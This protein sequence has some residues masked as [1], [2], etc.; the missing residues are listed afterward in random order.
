MPSSS[1]STSATGLLD[2]NETVDDRE[3]ARRFQIALDL[4]ETGVEI[5]R[6]NLRRR[7]P[8]ESDE[9]IQRRLAAWLADRPGAKYGDAPGRV[10]FLSPPHGG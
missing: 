6:Q 3:A 9:E 7:H 1:T 5:M 4:H 8:S 10:R 2:L